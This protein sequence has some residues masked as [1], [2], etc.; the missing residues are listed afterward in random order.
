MNY[1]EI[2]ILFFMVSDFR[3]H[4]Y[5]N[6]MTLVTALLKIGDG[7]M[8][9]RKSKSVINYFVNPLKNASKKELV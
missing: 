7:E 5:F 2:F 1:I 4:V 6:D 9:I 3:N 8:T